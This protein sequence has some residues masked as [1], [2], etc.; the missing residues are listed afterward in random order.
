VTSA[1]E[2]ATPDAAQ[3]EKLAESFILRGDISGLSPK[4]RALMYVRLC[5]R[6]GLSAD[7]QPF[8]ALKLNGKEIL[9]PTRGATD[10]LAA[11]HRLNRD[12]IDGPRVVD[13]GGVKLLYCKALVTHPNGRTETAIATLPGRVDENSLMKCETKAKR[14][15]TLSILGL[16]MLDETEV[17]AIPAEARA[18]ST[19]TPMTA[20]EIIATYDAAIA[21]GT[22]ADVAYA[23][24]K[25]LARDHK[26]AT[27]VQ[28]LLF[29]RERAEAE[30]K[31]AEIT[32]EVAEAVAAD[33]DESLLV[34]RQRMVAPPREHPACVAFVDQL[35]SAETPAAVVQVCRECLPALREAGAD[36]T[37]VAYREAEDAWHAVGGVG[38]LRD[39]LRKG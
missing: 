30:A 24:A 27:K 21:S 26:V 19:L 9:Y 23:D 11:I 38:A 31:R 4:E 17:E 22:P 3:A 6:L 36:V 7:T 39:A 8:A 35:A 15:A 34:N 12:I 25:S 10:Q 5:E 18:P 2:K 13:Y 32:A 28:A 33:L 14:R 20:A 1:I 16:G 29:E 37:S